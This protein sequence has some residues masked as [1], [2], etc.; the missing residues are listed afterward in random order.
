MRC[1]YAIRCGCKPHHCLP[2]CHPASKITNC[3]QNAIQHEPL[4]TKTQYSMDENK[5]IINSDKLVRLYYVYNGFIVLPIERERLGISSPPL[6]FEQLTLHYCSIATFS[7]RLS[8]GSIFVTLFIF[9]TFW[10]EVKHLNSL[11]NW[12]KLANCYW[13]NTFELIIIVSACTLCV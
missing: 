6:I 9:F 8:I 11:I 13:I 7:M 5:A 4:K 3:K 12:L 10:S 1:V 2:A